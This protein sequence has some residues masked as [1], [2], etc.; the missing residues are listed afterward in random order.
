MKNL[1]NSLQF[2]QKITFLLLAI[3]TMSL[4]WSPVALAHRPHDVVSQI[5][6]SPDFET[7]K[8]VYIVVRHNI[9]KSTDGGDNWQRKI[10][11]LDYKGEAGSLS[12]SPSEK[13]ILYFSTRSDGV[14]KSEDAGE[15]WKKINQGLDTE[16]IDRIEVAPSSSDIAVAAGID[17]NP[18]LGEKAGKI[19][20]GLYRTTDGGKTWSSILRSPAVINQIA[21][22]PKNPE[23]ILFGDTEGNLYLST[24]AGKTWQKL[25][26]PKDLGTV[27]AIA[28]SPNV[29]SDRTFFVGMIGKGIWKTENL[30]ESFEAI[31]Q[32]MG[33]SKIE[34]LVFSPNYA[35]DSTLYAST[36]QDGV[37]VSQDGGK[38]WKKRSE[39]LTRDHQ[40]DDFKEPHFTDLKVFGETIFLA[41]FNGLFRTVDGGQQWRELD[42]LLKG[43]VIAL[44]VSPNYEKDSTLAIANYVG[45]IFISNDQGETWAPANRGLEKFNFEPDREEASQDPRRFFDIAFSPA[46]GTD[47]TIFSS[48]LWTKIVKTENGGESWQIVSLDR[49]VRGIKIVPSPNFQVD[50]T[51]YLTNQAGK[52]FRS[53]NGGDNFTFTNE[54]G[55]IPGNYGPSMVISPNFTNDNTL[56]AT[57]KGGI[58]RYTTTASGSSWLNTTAGTPLENA[59]AIQL[60]ISPNYKVDGTVF[61]GSMQGLYVSENRGQIWQRIENTP[62]PIDSL[63]EGVAISPNYAND[64][65]VLITIRG[66]GLFQSTDAGKTFQAIG[67]SK[68]PISRTDRIP[69]AGIPIQFSPN[70]ANDRTIFG[71]G[72]AKTDVFRSTDGGKTWQTFTIPLNVEENTS[73]YKI[74]EFFSGNLGRLWRFLIP[75]VAA[76]A[77]YFLISALQLGKKFPFNKIAIGMIPAFVVFL[78]AFGFI[79]QF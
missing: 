35:T 68:L 52:I 38:T 33:D 2:L 77:A 11:G 16:Y 47:K 59:S 62:F 19:G 36:W 53:T 45:N 23:Q 32:D 21:I 79:A 44:A 25:P 49:P 76:I 41:G 5:E 65:T 60:A 50:R 30:G 64:R 9:Y 31:G 55:K 17:T 43:T 3:A 57:G 48:I 28:F 26:L 74:S 18:A 34:D 29:D 13:N 4:V 8:T 7:D 10:Q 12:L 70:Y 51:V 67:N 69:S 27:G 66:R 63:I 15:T 58:F 20:K 39:G 22:A 54:I 6:V 46:Y 73:R 71:F 75:A 37:Y 1:Q 24:D 78:L 42:T 56:F 61:A 72:G 40:A 14:Y